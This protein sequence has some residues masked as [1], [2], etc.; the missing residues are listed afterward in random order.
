MDERE[1]QE[2]HAGF[3]RN[4]KLHPGGCWNSNLLKSMIEQSMD[5][6]K[7]VVS[8]Q[9]KVVFPVCLNFCIRRTFTNRDALFRH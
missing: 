3:L 4:K 2:I 6:N 8:I 5:A 7:L 1:Y 9:K